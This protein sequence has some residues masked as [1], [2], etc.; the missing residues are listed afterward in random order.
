MVCNERAEYPLSF[1]TNVYNSP[2]INYSRFMLAT[3]LTLQSLSFMK[4]D[5]RVFPYSHEND[6]C[7]SCLPRKNSKK[8]LFCTV[9]ISSEKSV[10]T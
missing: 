10:S 8:V 1:L 7:L 9:M 4:Q 2:F 3:V 5:Q 6:H